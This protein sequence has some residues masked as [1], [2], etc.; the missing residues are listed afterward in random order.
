MT[1]SVS[2]DVTIKQKLM[3]IIMAIS[4]TSLLL[5]SLLF[6]LFQAGEIRRSLVEE[7]T[8]L[9]NVI[10]NNTQASLAFNDPVDAKQVLA[11]LRNNAAIMN[12]II[13]TDNGELFAT[14]KNQTARN[15]SYPVAPEE[16]HYEFKDRQLSL[17]QIIEDSNGKLGSI[18]LEANLDGLYAQIYK[19][20][21]VTVAIVLVA[22]FLC[23]FM[24]SRLQRLISRP[25]YE[26]SETTQTIRK[27]QDYSVR[28]DRDDYIEIR[29]LC[30]SFNS[31]LDQIQSREESLRQ[32]ASYD[33]LTKLPNRKF[34]LDLLSKALSRGKRRSHRHA[35]LFLDLDRFKHINDSLG[36]SAGDELLTLVAKRLLIILRGEDT[37]SRLGGDEYTILLQEITGTHQA[38][39][40]ANRILEVMNE[41]FHIQGHSVVIAPSIGIV[42]YPD[43][44]TTY[45]ELI[46][47]ADTA[48]YQAKHAGGN[49]Y[50]FF[51]EDMNRIAEK[52]QQLEE[53]LRYAFLNDEIIL[54][55]QPQVSLATGQIIGMEALCRWQ[56][57]KYE[58]IQPN[59]FIPI[60]EETGLIIPLT[61]IIMK[62]AVSMIKYWLDQGLYE[63]K[64]AI[65]VTA[66]QFMQTNIVNTLDS[67]VNEL[68][69]PAEHLEIEITEAAVMDHIGQ[70]IETMKKI[71]D[72]GITV[73]IDDFGT[74]YSSLSYLKKFP[75]DKLKI[76]KS[77]IHD[78]DD[79]TMNRNIVRSIIELGHTMN[80]SVV[81]E[82]VE[83][84]NQ[85]QML[86][87]L[88]CDSIQGFYFSKPVSN[89]EMEEL[90]KKHI[91]LYPDRNLFT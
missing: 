65:N 17:S 9:A 40:I 82:G 38:A 88:E 60:A 41:P 27:S 36:H 18:Y 85:V 79:S 24:S 75:I 81:A 71:K 35:V 68:K 80:L 56:K 64:I 67:I 16:Y 1:R 3:L 51:S 83:T 45:E 86:S 76:D 90:L 42:I 26:L 70:A 6:T 48:M 73:A 28:V 59:E 84:F 14:Y 47:N 5:A 44:G 19:N 29:H 54:N 91:T 52:R 21:Q 46:K 8:T 49:N 22:L 20:I 33:S 10:G 57:T 89:E 63:Y 7:L 72:R 30:D 69:L 66:R 13:Y 61:D 23:Y 32:L 25:I 15:V 31:M 55:Y 37:I 58:I 78:M 34:F 77:F 39:E 11:D 53:A 62:G 74:G 4:T 12:A 87:D 50:R 43:H 2:T